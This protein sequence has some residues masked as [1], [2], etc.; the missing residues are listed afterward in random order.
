MIT[1]AQALEHLADL[2]L[3]EEVTELFLSANARSVFRLGDQS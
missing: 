1:P 2:H 3:D